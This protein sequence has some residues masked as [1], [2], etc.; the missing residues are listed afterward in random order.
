MLP[1]SVGAKFIRYLPVW[2]AFNRA[3]KRQELLNLKADFEWGLQAAIET[4][5][6]TA[7]LTFPDFAPDYELVALSHADEYP[8]NEG[9]LISSSG[10]DIPVDDFEQ[11]FV[12]EHMAHSN[13][14]HAHRVGGGSYLVGP[15]ARLNLNMEKLSPLARESLAK[16][17]FKFPNNNPFVSI[18][19]RSIELV[20][21]FEEALSIIDQYERPSPSRIEAAPKAGEACYITEAPRGIL[22]HRYRLNEAGLIV[23]A[24]ISAPTSQN[25]KR[26]EDDLWA[27]V[28]DILELP[29][30]EATLRCEQLIRSYDPCI[31][32]A[33]HFLKLNV[34]GA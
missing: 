30:D 16:S 8:M 14:L 25:L 23:D 32:C 10:L 24:A 1:S 29:Q 33:T 13:A 3:P 28:P 15:L 22:Y 34:Q 5:S 19:A 9:R 7:G 12:E 27:F 11:Y 31:S 17:G 18:V 2:A 6:W 4:V 20:H 21:A 26:M